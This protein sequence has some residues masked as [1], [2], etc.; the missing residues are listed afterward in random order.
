[1]TLETESPKEIFI[2]RAGRPLHS[3][4]LVHTNLT[5]FYA[6]AYPHGFMALSVLVTHC[7][8]SCG[9]K[10]YG[11]YHEY[12]LF[13]FNHLKQCQTLMNFRQICH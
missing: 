6:P 12:F 11:I 9:K 7:H 10:K 2:W 8:G 1:M 4:F 3:F 5:E 13:D